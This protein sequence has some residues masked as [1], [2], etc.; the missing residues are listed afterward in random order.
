[1]KSSVGIIGSPWIIG[2]TTDGD[3]FTPIQI[4]YVYQ[5]CIVSY[6]VSY[7]TGPPSIPGTIRAYHLVPTARYG[8][9]SRVQGRPNNKLS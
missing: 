3:D 4:L 8:V 5:Y 6:P 9:Q 1:M 2:S 7:M